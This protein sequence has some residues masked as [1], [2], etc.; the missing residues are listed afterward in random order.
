[1]DEVVRCLGTLE[2]LSPSKEEY[3]RLCLLLTLARLSDHPEY[4]SWNPSAARV[5]CFVEVYPLVEKLL[6]P[7]LKGIQRP[8]GSSVS[9]DDRMI[10]VC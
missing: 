10:Q 3:N 6:P 4:S 9:R 8:G 7:D 1:V 2:R 5:Q